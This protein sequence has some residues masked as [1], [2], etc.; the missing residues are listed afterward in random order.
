M[1]VC[2]RCQ[3]EVPL[4]C[5]RFLYNAEAQS[6]KSHRRRPTSFLMVTPSLSTPSAS[7]RV[8]SVRRQ[9]ESTTRLSRA[10]CGVRGTSDHDDSNRTVQKVRK[11]VE[12][13]QVQLFDKVVDV[14][15]SMQRQAPTTLIMCE[16]LG[17]PQIEFIDRVVDTV[18]D[19]TSAHSAVIQ[20][21]T[22][23]PLAHA[24]ACFSV[25]CCCTHDSHHKTS[26]RRKQY[27]PVR[28]AYAAREARQKFGASG[29]L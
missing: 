14:P 8:S 19:L 18:T 5:A 9:A 20:K 27:E 13:S 22:C 21:K 23:H 7:S 3:G 17:F 1:R 15:V 11:T 12:V 29:K 28:R 16:N 6:G 2:A 10:S 24:F 4:H 26:S 25:F